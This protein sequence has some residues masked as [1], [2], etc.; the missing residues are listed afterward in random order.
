MT[1]HAF[2]VSQSKV[3]LFHVLYP[4]SLYKIDFLITAEMDRHKDF[5]F[6]FYIL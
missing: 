4:L 2:M 3:I 6:S 1:L 5:S